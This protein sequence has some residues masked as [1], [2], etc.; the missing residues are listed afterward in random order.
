METQSY[1]AFL[2]L[3]SNLGDR[4]TNLRLSIE[5]LERFDLKIIKLSSI[6]ETAAWGL[7]DQPA[8]LNQVIEVETEFLPGSLLMLCQEVE[9]QMGRQRVKKWGP[10]N[11]DVDI[12][13][14]EDEIMDEDDLMIPHPFMHERRF[15]LVPFCEIAPDLEHPVYDKT[16]KTLLKD[17]EDKLEVKKIA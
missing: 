8:F 11:I 9:A 5:L 10:R 6:Y 12:L 1:K 16:I 17:C 4:Q 14:Y 7:T 15:I 3:G 2:S 13:I